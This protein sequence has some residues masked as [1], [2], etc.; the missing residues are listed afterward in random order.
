MEDLLR[1]ADREGIFSDVRPSSAIIEELAGPIAPPP[2]QDVLDFGDS[3][4][5]GRG[6]RDGGRGGFGGGRDGGRG[7]GEKRNN[8]GGNGRGRWSDRPDGTP[9][10]R[11]KK[12]F[13]RRDG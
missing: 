13:E 3:R 6:G 2:V 1:R 10:P 7:Y 4:G 8:F 9:R 5:G 12:K 11:D